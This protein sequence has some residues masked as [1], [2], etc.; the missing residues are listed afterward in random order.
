MGATRHVGV[1]ILAAGAV[2]AIALFGSGGGAAQPAAGRAPTGSTAAL[3]RAPALPPVVS[4]N[5]ADFTYSP[6]GGT[7]V[8]SLSEDGSPGPGL[9]LTVYGMAVT[10][11]AHIYAQLTNDEGTAVV[12]PAGAAVAVTLGRPGTTSTVLTLDQPVTDRLEAG[13]TVQLDGS[14]AL[15]AYG[16]Y[17]VSG[18]LVGAGTAPAYALDRS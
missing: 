5:D 12:F 17:R 15:A 14:L 7:A 18:E 4:T 13:Q 1:G 10:G 3:V 16:T 2:A 9:V 11:T 6:K 8:S